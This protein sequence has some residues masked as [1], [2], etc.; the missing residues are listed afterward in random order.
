[1]NNKFLMGVIVAATGAILAQVVM[2]N[3]K[4]T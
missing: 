2:K 3:F 4:I 1:M